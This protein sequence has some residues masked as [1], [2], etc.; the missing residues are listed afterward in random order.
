MAMTAAMLGAALLHDAGAFS[1]TRFDVHPS[2]LSGCALL[3]GL[4]LAAVGPWRARLGGPEAERVARGR[5]ACFLAGVLIL[6]LVLNGPVHDLSDNFLFSAHMFQHLW[7]ML[8]VPPLWL[9]GLPAW[10]VRRALRVRGVRPVARSLTHPL[11]AYVAYNVVFLGWHLPIFYNAALVNHDLHIVQHLMFLA[12]ATMMWWPVLNPASELQ[13][14]PEGLLQMAYLFAFAVPATAVSAFI[15]MSDEVLYWFYE[16]APRLFGL[17]PLEDQR[18]GGLLMWVPG[19]LI[20]WAAIS[21]VYFRW[22]KDEIR[23]WRKAP[24]SRLSNRS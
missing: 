7:L 20:F 19:M 16:G 9:L 2:V 23:S 22:T 24:E 10:L 21:A 6:F 11:V 1:W 14:L 12:A 13:R 17:T 3:A 8:I 4:Y 18:L 5:V 15:T